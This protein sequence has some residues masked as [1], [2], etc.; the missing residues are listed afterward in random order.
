M[1]VIILPLCVAIGLTTFQVGRCEDWPGW[2]GPRRDGTSQETI[3]PWTA[4]PE[5]L[6]KTQVAEGHS[7]PIVA[8]G[9]VLLH[10]RVSGKNSE[11]LTARDLKT[12]KTVWVAENEREPFENSFGTGPRATPATSSGKVVSHGVTGVLACRDMATGKE[13]WKIDTLREFG[14][15][16][17]FF[18]A[19][20]SP[21]IHDGKVF[22]MVGGKQ[23]AVICLSLEDGK[24]IWKSM[25]ERASYSSPVLA[26]EGTKG[27]LLVLTQAGLASLDPATGKPDW[28]FPLVDKLNESSTTPVLLG[29]SIL[30]ASVTYGSVSLK[31]ADGKPEVNW[32][33]PSLT[34]YFSTPVPT[35]SG[36][37]LLAVTGRLLPP[38]S[39]VLRCV[40]TSTGKEL[41]SQQGVGKYHAA[42]MRLSD[43]R[44]LMHDDFGQISLFEANNE[45][46]KTLAKSKVCGPTWAHPALSGG[47]LVI[48]DDKELIALKVR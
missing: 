18:G 35:S 37:E 30:A 48:R 8:G 25:D 21:L 28:K 36:K 15:K 26:G 42:L 31:P 43:G 10:T 1:R 13:L 19:S 9:L 23:A 7:S 2:L 40:E 33:N 5:V 11:Q 20:S 14:G 41:W 27:R 34:C 16:N 29:G 32:K 3:T 44:F 39:S 4:Q 46:M 6:W 24:V 12:G 45:G 38:P 17:L 22:L 47:I